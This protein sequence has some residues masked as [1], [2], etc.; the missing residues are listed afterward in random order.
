[1]KIE[2]MKQN[3]EVKLEDIPEHLRD[4]YSPPPEERNLVVKIAGNREQYRL[5]YEKWEKQKMETLEKRVNKVLH[6]YNKMIKKM[7]SKDPEFGERFLSPMEVN[8]DSWLKMSTRDKIFRLLNPFEKVLVL[9]RYHALIKTFE[10]GVYKKLLKLSKKYMKLLNTHKIHFRN[11]TDDFLQKNILRQFELDMFKDDILRF[12]FDRIRKEEIEKY[13]V[14]QKFANQESEEGAR[15][16]RP[17]NKEEK[18]GR[19]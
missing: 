3:A 7:S 4:D 8:R 15:M 11:E 16:G 9:V 12:G 10:D 6:Y 5:L 1:M 17:I 2:E 18:L 14:S 13:K 19:C